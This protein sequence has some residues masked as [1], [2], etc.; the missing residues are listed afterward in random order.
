MSNNP[1]AAVRTVMS[2]PVATIPAEANVQ[3][4]AEALAADD[5]GV[6]LVLQ[7]GGLAGLISERDVVAV[8]GAGV[9]LSHLTVADAMAGDV[10]TTTAESTVLE[11]A[12]TMV[13][14]DVRHLPVLH[15]DL[16]AGLVSVRDVLAALVSGPDPGVVLLEATRATSATTT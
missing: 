7:D 12:R 6:L 16:I 3:E 14:A 13:A 10:V 5:I 9:D 8:V 1:Y 2:W 11:A 15:E 4:A